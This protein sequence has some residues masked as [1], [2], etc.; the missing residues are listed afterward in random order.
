MNGSSI[1]SPY[2]EDDPADR[3]A[4]RVVD[5]TT[6]HLVTAPKETVYGADSS[7]I[8]GAFV[9]RIHVPGDQAASVSGSAGRRLGHRQLSAMKRDLSVRDLS[10]LRSVADF[11]Y[12]TATQIEALHF[13]AHA[14]KLSGARKAR[15]ALQRL[16]EMRL[17]TRL[18]RRIGGVRAGSA[19]Y[20][21]GLGS[22]GQ[23]VLATNGERIRFKEPSLNFLSH[24]L[25]V[26]DLAIKLRTY[27]SVGL[28]EL[29]TQPEVVTEPACWRTF[30]TGMFGARQTLKPDLFVVTTNGQYEYRWFV[31]IDL[32]TESGTAVRRKAEIYL[33]YLKSGKEQQAHG[34]FPRVL[35]SANSKKRA[36]F[37]G[38]VLANVVAA[39]EGL[40]VVRE[41]DQAADALLGGDK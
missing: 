4:D 23:R 5:E 11:R 36:K 9:S 35:W 13:A 10:I 3:R 20:V 33:D 16:S 17:L 32:G 12:L 19:S 34:I 40:F 22:V 18:E 41:A 30:S 26:A 6:N 7:S 15:L 37:L 8:K 1:P 24:T 14:S 27:T 21:Y 29:R 39:P 28:A 25:A 38:N 2:R 31:E